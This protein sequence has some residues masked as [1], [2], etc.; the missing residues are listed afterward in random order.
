MN[1]GSLRYKSLVNF[2]NNRVKVG[3][4]VEFLPIKRDY[5]KLAGNFVRAYRDFGVLGGPAMVVVR[6]GERDEVG[7]ISYYKKLKVLDKPAME[8]K[9]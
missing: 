4:S 7:K 3:D 8:Y 1:I 6:I 9:L 2:V 5:P